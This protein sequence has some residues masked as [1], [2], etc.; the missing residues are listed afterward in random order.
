MTL[1]IPTPF[2]VLSPPP[3]S[4]PATPPSPS[5]R[6]R[7]LHRR[8]QALIESHSNAWIYAIL[9]RSSSNAILS[10]A[11][12]FYKGSLVP[13][14]KRRQSRNFSP[15]QE[16]RKS[17]LRVST[18][19][20]DEEVTDTEWFF[21]ISMTHSLVAPTFLPIQAQM[22]GETIWI[23]GYN[24]LIDTQCDRA[25]QAAALGIRTMACIPVAG[26]VLELGSTNEVF[27]NLETISR[28]RDSFGFHIA[29]S[30]PQFY[31][32]DP[33]SCGVSTSI[34][35]AGGSENSDRP[36]K[37]CRKTVKG[38]EVPLDHVEAERQRREKLNQLFYRLR[39]LVPNVSKMDK[40]SLLSDAIEY[41]TELRKKIGSLESCNESLRS[42]VDALK[43]NA[44]RVRRGFCGTEEKLE[45]VEMEVK[46]IEMEAMIR[47]QSK[48]KGYPPARFMAAL[49]A[50][51]L[52]L[53]YGSLSVVKDLMVQQVTVRMADCSSQEKLCKEIFARLGGDAAA[54]AAPANTRI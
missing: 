26:G 34:L 14:I 54:A 30:N 4:P 13:P 5:P 16:H 22:S 11:D 48:R 49:D 39:A 28:V 43:S 9:W 18:S 3:M 25:H 29:I 42:Q 6:R 8:L 36:R 1:L 46:V 35:K 47:V 2:H 52:E 38:P 15:A 31:T 50:V 41:I 19:A 51:G 53:L 24:R 23:S 44:D 20:I 37:R 17:V 7:T 40:A 10:W 33:I 12:G 21:L 27:E 32:E 45:G